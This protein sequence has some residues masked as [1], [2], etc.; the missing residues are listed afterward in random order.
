MNLNKKE[1]SMKWFR[2][3]FVVVLVAMTSE[4]ACCAQIWPCPGVCFTDGAYFPDLEKGV[5]FLDLGL[6]QTERPSVYGLSFALWRSRY[7]TMVGAHVGLLEGIGADV[8]GAQMGLANSA[9]RGAGVQLGLF[10]VYDDVS[11]RIQ[12]GLLNSYRLSLNWNYG[13]PSHSG[14]CGVQ[15]GLVNMSSE[16]GHLQVGF[17][18][19]A[20]ESTVFQV[21][22]YNSMNKKSCGLQIGVIN[23]VGDKGL[24]FIGWNW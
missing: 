2:I 18:N 4:V 12:A 14:G 8:Y 9:G 10:N 23:E 16:G 17:L 13:T 7:K 22:V 20:S 6:P 11:F 15:L 21:G 1:R 3:L 24:P 5:V 19:F